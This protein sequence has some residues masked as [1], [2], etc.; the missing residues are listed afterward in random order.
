MS[1][2]HLGKPNKKQ[3]PKYPRRCSVEVTDVRILEAMRALTIGSPYSFNYLAEE[4]FKI[5]LPSL[6][7]KV[8]LAKQVFLMPA[9]A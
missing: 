2:E 5:A 4:A 7:E 6:K 1:E 3:P 8:Q 9:A